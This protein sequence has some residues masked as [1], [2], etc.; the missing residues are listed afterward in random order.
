MEFAIA[1]PARPDAWR[2]VVIAEDNGFTHA[3]FYDSQMIYSDV[4]VCM[5]LAAEHTKRIKLAT[6]VAI[7]SNRIEPVTAHSIATINLLAPGRTILGIGT[8]FTGRNTMGLPPVPLGQV[9][10]Y[11]KMVR[12]L[13]HGEE[14]M[15]RDGKLERAIRFLHPHHGY[16]NLEDK[17]PIYL[18]ADGPKALELVGEL[19][20]GW[21]TVLSGPERFREKFESVKKGA[22]RAGRSVENLPNAVLTSGCILRDGESAVSPR[23]LE[24][25]GPFAIVFLHA[26]WEQS[27]VAAAL[28]AALTKLWERYRDEYVAKMKTA[29]GKRYLEVHEGHLIYMKPGEEQYIDETLVR[30]MTLTGRGDEI[31]ARLKALEAAGVKQV[32]IQVVWPHGREMIEDFSREV[33]ARY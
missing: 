11:I 5:A 18:A 12:S 29:P 17:I 10:S 21:V 30:S 3:W 20:D 28:P 26:L 8:G 13:L 27:A 4:Y 19:A 31:I 14:V 25:M 16:I 9:R 6:G 33:I 15:Y 7:P 1:Y 32:A 23:V 2:D 24:R 22:Q